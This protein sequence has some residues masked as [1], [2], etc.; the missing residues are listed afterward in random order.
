MSDG[1][2]EPDE[3]TDASGDET[4]PEVS[5]DERLDAAEADLDDAET[6]ADLDAV[7]AELDGVEADLEAADLPEPEDEDEADPAEELESR[8]S[9]L[10]DDLAEQR[11]PYAEDVTAEVEDAKSEIESTR[12]TEQGES[13]LVGVVDAFAE[14]VSETLDAD[15][16]TRGDD[17]DAL[18]ATLDDAAGAVEAAALAADEDAETIADLLAAADE[19]VA[20]VEGA[21]AW[22]DLSVREKLR[23]EGYFDVLGQKHK[24]FPPEWSALKEWEQRGNAE[25]I[26]LALDYLGDSGFMERHC[27]EALERMGHP[28]SF[29]EMESRA[30]KRDKDAIA[31]LGKIGDESAL[32]TILEYVDADSDP[33]LQMAAMRAVGEIGSEEATQTVANQLVAENETVRSHA[34]R[35]L[36]LLGDARAVEPLAVMLDEDDSQEVRASA[37]WA[38]VQIGTQEALEAA[39]EYAD[40]HSYLVTAE[41]EVAAGALAT[42]PSA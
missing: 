19:L 4:L 21:Q 34:A 23:A 41:A 7:E 27:L 20:G 35:T 11:G 9:D 16:E 1:D 40:D 12:W 14:T 32:D 10:R 30:G 29:D 18:A 36:G 26:L 22:D 37:A 8:L 28:A 15:V 17:L 33:Q 13:D 38:L 39:A 5:L 3:E 31:V 24:D 25:M 6:E 42:A 2:E